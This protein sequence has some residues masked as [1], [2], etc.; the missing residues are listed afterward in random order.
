MALGGCDFRHP[1]SGN[2]IFPDPQK[3]KEYYGVIT[4]ITK[5]SSLTKQNT[6]SI[7]LR[8]VPDSLLYYYSESYHFNQPNYKDFTYMWSGH[9]KKQSSWLITM[10]D[11]PFIYSYSIPANLIFLNGTFT[12]HKEN[13]DW[14]L[15]QSVSDHSIKINLTDTKPDTLQ[16]PYP[17]HLICQ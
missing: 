15:Q 2:D 4:Y 6:A 7:R 12:Y 8:F 16:L 17:D 5:D 10:N 1:G 13:G 9:Y 11:C 3:G 14:I